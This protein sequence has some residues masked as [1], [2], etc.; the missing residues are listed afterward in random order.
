MRAPASPFLA[1]PGREHRSPGKREE[2]SP[3]IA[4]HLRPCP[5]GL[6]ECAVSAWLGSPCTESACN[7]V[8]LADLM[9]GHQTGATAALLLRQPAPVRVTCG[10]AA[11]RTAA[12]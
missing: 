10:F 8:P 3:T 2:P 4:A 9:T 6:S 12:R 5:V 11:G 1:H 7:A